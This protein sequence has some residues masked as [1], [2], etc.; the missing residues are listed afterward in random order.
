MTVPVRV[1]ISQLDHWAEMGAA[2]IRA[3]YF[4]ADTAPIGFIVVPPTDPNAA[5][6][7]L[8][9][10]IVA[11]R[12]YLINLIHATSHVF[13]AET[14][15]AGADIFAQPFWVEAMPRQQRSWFI[16]PSGRTSWACVLYT[17]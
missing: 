3:T 8:N 13:P 7:A 1:P 4:S 12:S 2:A 6:K 11:L 16:L 5:L 9:P 17:H 15:G 14:D 10:P